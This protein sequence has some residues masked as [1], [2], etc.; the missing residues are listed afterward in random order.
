M[1]SQQKRI[2]LVTRHASDLFDIVEP[3]FGFIEELAC[4]FL[5]DVGLVIMLLRFCGICMRA[6]LT[7]CL[8]LLFTMGFLWGALY[9]CWLVEL[10]L[11]ETAIAH[12]VW[13]LTQFPHH[14]FF[15]SL[16]F[17]KNSKFLKLF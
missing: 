1:R 14:L 17:V 9:W 15:L 3:K 4:R 2:E 5:L 12:Q 8:L 6:G 7:S 13:L 11:L 10:P 16:I